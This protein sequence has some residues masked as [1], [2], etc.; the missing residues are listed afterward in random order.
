MQ[1][2]GGEGRE[3]T[4]LFGTLNL[5]WQ[6]FEKKTFTKI[7]AYAGMYEPLVRYLE[8]KEVLQKEIKDTLEHNNQSYGERSAQTDKRL[9]NTS[10]T[11]L[12]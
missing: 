3:S 12:I 2:I 5:P 1:L 6:G 9:N 11:D 7:G 10:F 4:N 8:I